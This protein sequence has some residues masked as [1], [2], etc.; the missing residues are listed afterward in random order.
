[1]GALMCV[2][3]VSVPVSRHRSFP[4]GISHTFLLINVAVGH[5]QPDLHG[6]WL[7]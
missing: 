4:W 1:M 6:Y 7:S 2:L 5:H 3:K